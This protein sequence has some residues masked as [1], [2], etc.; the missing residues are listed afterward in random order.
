MD[1][2]KSRLG[3]RDL[4]ID[5]AAP[6]ASARPGGIGFRNVMRFGGV[7]LADCFFEANDGVRVGASQVTV[8]IYGGSDFQMDWRLPE[9]DR[10]YSGAISHGQAH[11][12]DG[13]LPLWARCHTSPSFFAFAMDDALIRRACQDAFHGVTDLQLQTSIGV[14][15][16]VIRR[17]GAVAQL[18]LGQGGANGR[19]YVESLGSALAV[20]LLRTYGRLKK[21]AK[22]HK[23]GLAPVQFRRVAEYIEANLSEELSLS[24]LAA[25]A[26]LSAHHFLQAFKMETGRTPHGYVTEK[27]VHRAREMLRDGETP[28]AQIAHAVGFSSQSHFT[29]NF[30][31]MTG[32]TPAR[33]RHL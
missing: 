3:L 32:V 7:T 2:F 13:R 30:R 25:V 12:G 9:S 33:F 14:D 27:R 24:D 28:I 4:T 6:A 5:F 11:I 8:G 20:H 22:L 10:L 15:D 23:G 18:E 26:G 21:P 19:L 31:R 16:P 17:I 1:S 29:F